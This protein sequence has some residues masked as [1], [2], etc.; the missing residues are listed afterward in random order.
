M[1]PLATSSRGR[2]AA[3]A[4]AL[5]CASSLLLAGCGRPDDAGATAAP[6]TSID[7]APA[8]G[9]VD[10]WAPSGDA[11]NLDALLADFR[12]ENP[13]ATVNVTVIPNDEYP[14]KIQAAIASDTLPDV[15][16]VKA[17]GSLLAG[18]WTPVPDGLVEL[19]DF[20]TGT[21]ALGQ[22]DD[23]QYLVPWYNNVRL[24]IYRAD[25]AESGAV[26]PPATWSDWTPFL[27][28]LEAGGATQAF[29]N[30]VAWDANTG[31]FIATLG[32]SAGAELVSDDGDQ[33]QIDTP[34]MRDAMEQYASF[35]EDGLSS[36][37][38]P[39][40][41]DQVSTFVSGEIGSLVTGP[42]VLAQ[43]TS[44]AGADW[45]D[46]NVG[47]A[48]LPAGPGGSVGA[49][50]G[51]GWTVAESS[52]N[53]DSAWKVIRYLGQVDTELAQYDGFGSLPPRTTAWEKGGL[54][55]NPHL[56]PFFAQMDT[57]V[58]PPNVATWNQ[59]TKMLGGQAEKLVRGGVAVDDVLAEAQS[60]ADSIGMGN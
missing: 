14:Q 6:T 9:V 13:D 19:D 49:L 55:E 4:V 34:E 32:F 48:V 42:W 40:F 31:L 16:L 44:A 2:K 29:G 39:G 28:G 56:E 51:G 46:Q 18:T 12:S 52:D 11:N 45:V 22:L 7:D 60:L 50:V 15:V 41:L 23:V 20:F 21:L 36:P 17:D 33:W 47:V 58:A 38:G 24:L 8:T 59:I 57:S 30:D 3:A 10:V 1:P 5:L 26:E 53:A 25:F 27:E 54:T 37:D 35:F 43:L